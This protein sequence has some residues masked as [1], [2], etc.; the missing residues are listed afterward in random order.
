MASSSHFA[1][2]VPMSM[3]E[4]AELLEDCGD[5]VITVQF[6]KQANVEATVELLQAASFKD[7][8]D[9]KKLSA[10]SKS[11]VEGE[12][13]TM[14]CHLVQTEN[15]LGRS[16]VIDLGSKSDNKF[17]QVDH[18]S[19]EFVIFKNAKYVLKKGAKKADVDMKDEEKK[20]KDEPLWDRKQLAVGNWFSGT[21]YYK[22]K[23]I[24]G[25]QV[26]TRSDGKSITISRDILEYE[27][28]NA[29]VFT[30][31]EK[32]PLTKV[33]K[34]LKEA[35]ST[36]FTINFNCKVDDKQ[37][38]EKL[39]AC[40]EKEFKESKSLAKELL[41]GKES[42]IIGRLSKSEGKLGRSLM[43][44]LENAMYAQVDHR[45]INW[46]ILKNVKYIVKH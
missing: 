43:I 38:A 11:I 37:V 5:T 22:V 36:A 7:L 45:T 44:N 24:D 26:E 19:I 35:H 18:R 14:V 30:K 21:A 13:C 12:V 40:S 34:V 31:E 39:K 15:L 3:T 42:T 9:Q 20:N 27:M 46:I 1:K 23:K 17:R 33:V 28:H 32:L 41:L 4:L 29:C 8:K 10:L 6:R 25:D 2:E 16:T